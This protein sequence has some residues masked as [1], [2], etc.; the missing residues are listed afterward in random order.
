MDYKVETFTLPPTPH[1]YIWSKD[2]IDEYM[3]TNEGNPYACMGVSC[4]TFNKMNDDDQ[5]SYCTEIKPNDIVGTVT[6]MEE[7]DGKLMA[8]VSVNPDFVMSKCLIDLLHSPCKDTVGYAFVGCGQYES[9]N[10]VVHGTI[11]SLRIKPFEVDN[12]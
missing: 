12:D 5:D 4:D 3:H 1:S 6:A 10:K 8:T 7:K 2:S 11:A 9:D